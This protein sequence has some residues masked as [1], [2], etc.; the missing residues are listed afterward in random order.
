MKVIGLFALLALT[1]GI[2]DCFGGKKAEKAVDPTAETA[3][4]E[5]GA[6]APAAEEA[7][8]A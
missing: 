6:V 3:S 5:E 4:S 7:T 1:A 8:K 2:S